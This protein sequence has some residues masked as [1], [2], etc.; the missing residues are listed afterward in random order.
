MVKK[1]IEISRERTSLSI[2]YG[3]LVIRYSTSDG[4][5]EPPVKPAAKYT[6]KQYRSGQEERSI[7]CEDIGVLLI[8]NPATVYTH[9][10]FTELLKHNA[11]VIFCD[12]SHLP[13]GCLLP[14]ESNTTQTESFAKQINVKEPIKKKLWQQLIRAKISH[15]A[16]IVKDNTQIYLALYSFRSS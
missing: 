11:A 3:Q 7:P 9:S 2:K 6:A 1:I 8:D 13:A 4:G 12:N 16:K 15:Q 10:V 14:I 5:K